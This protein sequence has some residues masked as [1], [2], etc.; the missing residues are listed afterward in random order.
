MRLDLTDLSPFCWK[1]WEEIAPIIQVIFE[2]SIKIGKLQGDWCKAQVTPVFTKGISRLPPITDLSPWLTLEHIL[3]SH[4]V[5]QLDKHDLLYD[6][7]HTCSFRRKRSWETQLT[8]LV[9]DLARNVSADNLY[10]FLHNPKPSCEYY[11]D[12]ICTYCVSS[13]SS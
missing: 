10:L 12:V 1:N 8:V 5:K 9:E 3:A 7:Q 13:I 2:R 11:L 6:L 4:L